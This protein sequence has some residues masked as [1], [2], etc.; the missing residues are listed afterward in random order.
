MSD[1]YILITS[2]L[3]LAVGPILQQLGR[4]V[5][6]MQ[7]ILDGFVFIAI[8]GLILLHVI[9]GSIVLGGWLAI[10]GGLLGLLVPS[11]IES[12]LHGLAR[13]AHMVALVLALSG[14]M[15][16]GF[17][18]GLALIAPEEA[19]G[20]HVHSMLPLAVIL[21]RLPVGLTI[22]ILL[23][24]LYGT[25]AALGTLV[26]IAFA[27]VAGFV[28]GGTVFEGVDNR[29][30]GM[31]QAL[32]A[33]SL[34]HVVM[35]RSHPHGEPEELAGRGRLHAGLGALGGL[36]LLWGITLSHGGE[37]MVWQGGGILGLGGLFA[38]ILWRR[39][40]HWYASAHE[41]HHCS[42]SGANHQEGGAE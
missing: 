14:I 30:S 15:L 12:R 18:D 1:S 32:V 3:T 41:H 27:T 6:P 26:L 16:H 36:T 25:G 39:G 42:G 20:A 13:Q 24:P 2:I 11:L 23:R 17:V 37:S 28:L 10:L 19:E 40:S 35:H 8:S 4:R 5:G 31:F 22:W 9:P 34:L 7:A 29:I 38:L 21:H 33:G